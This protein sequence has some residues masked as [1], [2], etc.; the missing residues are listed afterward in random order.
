MADDN[1]RIHVSATEA[2]AG[3]T[4]GVTR[5][6]L[7]ISLIAAIAVMAYILLT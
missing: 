3:A 7:A 5:Y 1:D 6:V 2:R 4:P